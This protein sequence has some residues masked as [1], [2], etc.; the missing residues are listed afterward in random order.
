[1]PYKKGYRRNFRRGKK[2]YTKKAGTGTMYKIAKRVLNN[3]VEHKQ[4]TDF[5]FQNSLTSTAAVVRMFGSG[6]GGSNNGGIVQGV[7]DKT[8]I[9]VKIRPKALVIRG[10]VQM[11]PSF[12]G[13]NQI[14]RVAVLQYKNDDGRT[15]T[16]TSD[17]Y[18]SADI[19]TNKKW[20]ERF[21]SRTLWDKTFTLSDMMSS[22]VFK[23]VLKP[24]DISFKVNAVPGTPD[25]IYSTGGLYL[26]VWQDNTSSTNSPAFECFYNMSYT[27]I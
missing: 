3:N 23:V 15:L 24:R 12:T 13:N 18:D 8:R 27:D 9:G 21:N 17:F 2:R 6:A 26:L 16:M 5:Q 25:A 20:D 19:N 7:T 14:V 11:N 4:Y 10:N 22:R 1:M